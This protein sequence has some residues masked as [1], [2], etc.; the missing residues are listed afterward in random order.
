MQSQIPLIVHEFEKSKRCLPCF[1]KEWPDLGAQ[2]TG[3]TLCSI[4]EDDGG[5]P[6]QRAAQQNGL[7]GRHFAASLPHES[8]V[9][10]GELGDLSCDSGKPRSATTDHLCK[11]C[12]DAKV[13]RIAA[14]CPRVPHPRKKQKVGGE[15]S[16]SSRG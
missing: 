5:G 14:A 12:F 6:C 15:P 13:K 2:L 1:K 4:E 9:C 10:F 16:T 8:T 3:I 7:C 11:P